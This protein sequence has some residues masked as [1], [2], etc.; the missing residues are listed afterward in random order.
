M[1]RVSKIPEGLLN[2]DNS[3]ND[4]IYNNFL[5]KLSSTFEKQLFRIIK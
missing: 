2:G 4:K 1:L 3:Y 5:D